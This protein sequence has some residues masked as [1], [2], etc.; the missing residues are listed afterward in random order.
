M[1]GNIAAQGTTYKDGQM[2]F[3]EF[4]RGDGFYLILSGKVEL[5]R[6]V[7]DVSKTLDVLHKTEMFGEMSMLEDSPRSASAI[8]LGETRLM[9]F[10]STNFQNL[11]LSNPQL[12]IKLLK[13][14]VK[15]I[16]D[17]KR[18]YMILTL[19]EPNARVADVFLMLDETTISDSAAI[20]THRRV[21]TTTVENIARWGGLSLSA[22]KDSIAYYTKLG[23]MEVL[24]DRIVLKDINNFSRIVTTA[25]SKKFR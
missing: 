21:F 3:S 8:A 17:A 9:K 18:R 14:F 1:A 15:R 2:I 5:V 4:E 11:V 25:R 12:S 23:Y 16:Y 6:I 7:G 19:N 22:A 10:D 24:P 20:E 13:M